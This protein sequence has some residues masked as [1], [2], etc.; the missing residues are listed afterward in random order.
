MTL[1]RRG[2]SHPQ[3]G[4]AGVLLLRRLSGAAYHADAAVASA[5]SSTAA[6]AVTVDAAPLEVHVELTAV[7]PLK[8]APLPHAVVRARE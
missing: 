3:A 7:A 2:A 1:T 4:H 8:A 6:A 5:S